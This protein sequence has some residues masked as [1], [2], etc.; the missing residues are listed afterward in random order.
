M[1]PIFLSLLPIFLLI[2]LGYGL[3]RISFKSDDFW[4][5]LERLI[6]FVLFPALIIDSLAKANLSSLNVIPMS[7]ALALATVAISGIVILAKKL[8][9]VDGPAFGS[10]FMGATR[11]NTY[12]GIAAAGALY[13]NDGLALAALT[14]AVLVPLVNFLSIL[15]LIKYASTADE[16]SFWRAIIWPLVT[17]PLIVASSLGIVLNAVSWQLPIGI[18]A[19]ISALGFAALPLG[20]LAVGAGLKSEI[21]GAAK[22][23][24]AWSSAF[25]LIAMPVAMVLACRCLGLTGLPAHVAILF[26]AL[27]SASTAYIIA[28][29]M[30]GDAPLMAGI[31]TITTLIAAITMP[32]IMAYVKMSTALA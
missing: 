2:S 20:L 3:K 10:I 26:A 25:K 15:V 13:G 19:M 11:F 31:I 23:P 18:D 29:Q 22:I 1:N 17:N 6:Y 4:F 32:L 27:P 8:V 30:G 28:R 9:N 16:H 5:S 24:L 14:I 21:I 12:V 7:A